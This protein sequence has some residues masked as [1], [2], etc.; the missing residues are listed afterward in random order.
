M[1][2]IYLN[3]RQFSKQLSKRSGVRVNVKLINVFSYIQKRYSKMAHSSTE[4]Y[5]NKKYNY[6]SRRFSSF[7]DILNSFY[8]LAYVSKAE[9]L[10]INMLQITMSNM[11]KKGFR[12]KH[13]FYFL[14]AVANNMNILKKTFNAF[15]FI[16]TGKLGGG[17]GRTKTLSLGFGDLPSQTL[18][19]N[20]RYA[21][22]DLHSK[23]GA[24]GL[25]LFT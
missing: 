6:Y 4:I 2:D 1:S 23:Y 9:K 17:T 14:D 11:H 18:K 8:I 13:F 3:P 20:F 10:F 12:P 16:I 7:Y 19:I 22:G 5:F 15:R 25:R 21:F 24:Y